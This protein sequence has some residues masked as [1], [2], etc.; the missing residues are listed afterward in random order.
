MERRDFLKGMAATGMLAATSA[1]AN[2]SSSDIDRHVIKIRAFDY[3]GVRLH[4]SRWN[5]QY[6]HAREFYFNV[7]DDDILHGFRAKAGLPAPGKPLGGWCDQ[8]SS[9]VFGQWL[10]GMSRM[11][12][13][14][15]DQAMRD[16]AMYLFAEFAKTVGPEG[17]CRM[18]VYPYEKLVCGLVD[19]QQYAGESRALPLLERVTAYAT[20]TF[21]RTR[22][23]AAPK[24]WE[25]HSGKPLEWYTQ[26]E[27][28]FRAYQLTGNKEFKD[29]AEVWLY[30]SYWDKFSGTSSPPDAA[31]VH[32][33]S[34]VNSFSSASMRYAVTGDP[35]HLRVVENAYDFLQNTQCYATGG[36][37]PVERIMPSGSLGRAL[38]YQLNSFETPCGSWA[39]FKMSRY[40]MQFTGKARYGDWAE[41]LLYNGIGSALQINGNGRHF[42]YADYRVGGGVKVF[43]RNAYT[44]C[45]GTYIQDVADFH[46]LIYYKDDSSLYVNLYVPSDVTWN[47]SDGTVRLVQDTRYPEAETSTLTLQ[48]NGSMRFPLRMRIP[49]WAKGASLKVN[50]APHQTSCEPGAWA[51]VDRVWNSGDKVEITIPLR[52]RWQAVDAQHPHRVA[53]VRGPVV[54]VQDGMIHEPIFKL[55]ENDDGLN[56]YLVADNEEGPGVFRFAPPD[57]SKVMAKF[58]P[59][60]SV[61]GDYYYRMYFD[62]DKLPVVL[63]Q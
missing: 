44:C 32:A 56:K 40:L 57:G 11:Y 54:L 3:D 16:K 20:K 62:L 60:Y 39:G 27:N 48:T 55:P 59:F 43:S 35:A 58:R 15:G 7:S 61:G 18:D 23:P 26:P 50:G 36:Y 34:H 14:T 6:L 19:M 9:T 30:E 24:P 46:N 38:D 45:S 47:R 12:R 4:H 51:T 13:A 42:Y 17:D 37:G 28:L 52:M 5:D 21:D 1:R 22:Q 49:E 2:T 8:D 53:L 29:F 63:W 31:G 41:R 33:Y 10:S 25:M